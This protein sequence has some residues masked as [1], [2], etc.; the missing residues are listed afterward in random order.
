[1]ENRRMKSMR[2]LGAATLRLAVGIALVTGAPAAA[3][4][5]GQDQVSETEYARAEQF[6]TWNSSQMVVGDAVSPQWLSDGNRFWYRVTRPD[7]ADFVLVDPA[8][9]Q[10]RLLFDR[11]RLAAAMSMAADTAYD[12]VRLPFTTLD[13]VEEVSDIQFR[14]SHRLFR[15]DIQDYR[16]TVGDTLP[17]AGPAFVASPDSTQEA[18]VHEHN[19]WIRSLGGGDSIQLTTDGEG[20]WAYGLIAPR[21]YVQFQGE[22]DARS[23]QL[24][25]S[26]DGSTIAVIRVD[27]REIPHV[28]MYSSTSQRPQGWSYPYA[29]PGD[30]LIPIPALYLVDVEGRSSRRVEIEPEPAFVGFATDMDS[31]W[32]DDSR[33]VRI[34]SK[35][36]GHQHQQLVEVEAAS[37]MAHVLAVESN[38]TYIDMNHNGPD[39]WWAG[40][41]ASPGSDAATDDVFLFSQRDGWGHIWRFGR[42][43]QVRNQVTSGPWTVG[44]IHHVDAGQQRVYFTAWGR[45]EGH[46]PYHAH[47]YR[48]NFDGSELTLLTP[49]PAE[50]IVAMAPSGQYF[51]DTHSTLQRPPVTVVRSADDGQVIRI[52]E[53]ADISRL[54]AMGWQAPEPFVAKGRDGVTDI[55]GVIYK[56]SNFDPSKT[57]PVLD[58]IY[59]GPQIIVSPQVFFPTNQPGLTYATFGQVQ[60][61][62]ELG[63]IVVHID[64]MG[65]IMRSKAF[66]DIYYGD[67]ADHGLPDHIAVLRSL[68]AERPYLDLDRV[69]IYGHSGGGFASTAAILQYP[70]VFD[71][72]VSTSGN[73][74]NRT[75]GI[76]WGEKY[77]GL[78]VRDTINDTDNYASQANQERAENLQGKLFLIT[79]DLDDN[80][81]PAMTFQVA[82]E[83]IRHNKDFDF[84]IMPDRAHGITQEP[85]VIRRTWDYFV[86][87]LQ[88]REPPE[89]YLLKEPGG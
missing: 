78:L 74:D 7:G 30:S 69:G 40:G 41:G 8:A 87:H 44:T 79:G 34:W 36:R 76:H 62:A 83:L 52:L 54:L 33:F 22:A 63:F 3:H 29:L 67:M 84:L 89:E 72:A 86:R 88:G 48:V 71:V 75:Y 42:D 66:H 11:A 31:T 50:H 64:H 59:P 39:N 25:W 21:A 43:G 2:R 60:A 16:C 1:M 53:E 46:H 49:E 12:P 28:P 6:L 85:Y 77:Q 4:L 19:L 61:V 45:E 15:C 73:H 81:H 23:P 24:E 70:D 56:P 27:E 32:T 47:F 65:T 57:Y 80:V 10:Q 82:N 5:A 9:D 37:A 14:A 17:D 18:F 13:F 26:P 20:F 35:T 38:Q 58:H 68:A 55:H 51:V